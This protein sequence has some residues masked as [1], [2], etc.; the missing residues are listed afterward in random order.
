MPHAAFQQ[1]AQPLFD[2]G[3]VEVLEWSFDISWGTK[4]LPQWVL[5]RLEQFSEQHQLL[6][7]GVSYSLLSARHESSHW[8]ACLEAECKQYHYQHISEHFGW[9][10]TRTFGD[11]APLPMPFLPEVLKVGCDRIQKLADIAQVPMGLENLAFAFSL[12]DVR[13][14]GPFLEQLL[15]PVDGFLLLDLHNLYC[16]LCNFQ[17]SAADLLNLYPLE[18]VQELHLSGGSWSEGIAGKIR[19]DTHD[20]AIP[21]PVFELLTLVLARC[22]NLKAVIIERLG[23]TLTSVSEHHQFRQDFIRVRDILANPG[24]GEGQYNDRG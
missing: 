10:A 20:Q 4:A 16:Q 3:L 17:I 24:A 7:H 6:G 2:A 15:K 19:R 11:S 1:A 14:Q 5:E 8:L 12:Q 22:P 23:D 9:S 13:D 18:L 21:E